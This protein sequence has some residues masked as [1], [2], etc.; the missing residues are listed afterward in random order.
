MAC[1]KDFLDTR[2]DK[3]LLV[4]TT[5]SD[6]RSLL[7]NTQVFNSRYNLTAI[8]DGDFFTDENGF[9]AY[10]LDQE[11][12]S[13][14]WAKEIFAGNL[15]PDWT[16]AYQQ[17][18]YA[19]VVLEGIARLSAED[20]RSAEGKAIKGTALFHR[21]FAYYGLL[22]EF[23][24]PF[25]KQSA[26]TMP[27]IPLKSKADVTEKVGRGTV[28]EVFTRIWSDLN[29]ARTLLPATTAYKTRPTLT[30][31]QALKARI[32]LSTADY[33][34]AEKFADSAL[35]SKGSLMDYNLLNPQASRPFP[36][37]LPNGNDEAIFYTALNPYSFN[38]A[39]SATYIDTALYDSYDAHDLRKQIFF[40][41][42]SAGRYQFKGNYTGTL[43][44]F[45]G[46]ATDEL[47]LIR[48][49][50]RARTGNTQAALTDLNALLVKRWEK[51]YFKPL[52]SND[53]GQVL[54][55][56]IAER[57][58]E[59]IGR[60]LRWEDLRRLNQENRFSVTLLRSINGQR[61]ELA[62]N[63]KRYAYPIPD[64]EVKLNG[65]VQNER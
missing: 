40:Q 3:S 62:P 60:N 16:N 5:L 15:T 41:Q 63:D 53:A 9:S 58:K 59:L 52:Q 17:V 20:A 18:F 6:L 31:L 37:I 42:K 24:S 33:G 36:R 10:Y 27:G 54:G 44:L 39:S 23:T 8:A 11:R 2:P 35:L 25:N 19:N 21:A 65:L 32:A 28:E 45:G 12:N 47:Y 34:Q 57:R 7:D 46:L 22:C 30:S 38:L 1:K 61:Y 49:E 50:C 29:A 14:V 4:P 26:G 56:V 48:A 43:A 13:Y 55:W 64:M 51:G